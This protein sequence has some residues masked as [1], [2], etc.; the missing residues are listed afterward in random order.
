MLTDEFD[1]I[2]ARPFTSG[3]F[4]DLYRA[5]YKGQLVVAKALK[6]ASTGDP[7]SENAHK[8]SDLTSCRIV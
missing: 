3:G 6:A 4:A 2:E 1:D 7:D 5:T 8:V